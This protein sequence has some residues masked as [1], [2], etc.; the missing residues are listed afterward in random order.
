[1]FVSGGLDANAGA[2]ECRQ[3]LE[4]ALVKE[5]SAMAQ[6]FVLQIFFAILLILLCVPIAVLVHPVSLHSL[7]KD[8]Q[9]RHVVHCN[10]WQPLRGSDLKPAAYVR[11]FDLS[12]PRVCSIDIGTPLSVRALAMQE[13]Q[14]GSDCN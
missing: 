4:A 5:V 11:R 6:L 9:R 2:W 1:M 7:H 8:E 12:N 13:L 3:E 10:L 14:A